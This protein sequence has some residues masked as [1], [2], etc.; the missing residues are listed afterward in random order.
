MLKIGEKADEDEKEREEAQ[1]GEGS[2]RLPSEGPSLARELKRM[3][4]QTR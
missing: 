1:E 2:G 4:W 3:R